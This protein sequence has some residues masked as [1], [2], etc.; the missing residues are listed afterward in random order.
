MKNK[1]LAAISISFAVIG[2]LGLNSVLASSNAGGSEDPVVTKSY[3]DKKLAEI[4]GGSSSAE[5]SE[6]QLEFIIEEVKRELGQG[7]ATGSYVPVQVFAGQTLIGQEGTEVILRS[8]SASVYTEGVDG[9]VNVTSGQDIKNGN[10]VEKNNLL[11]IPRSDGR[12]VTCTLD[13]WFMVKGGYSI[14]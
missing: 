1:K 12:G 13:S 6:Y 11:I 5:L 3:V 8:G 7:N 2:L 10:G 14:K 9:I 4:S